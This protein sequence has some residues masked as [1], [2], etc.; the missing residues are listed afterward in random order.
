[1]EWVVFVTS[2]RLARK[3]ARVLAEEA[4]E[5]GAVVRA[6]GGS[7]ERDTVASRILQVLDRPRTA[8]QIADM[9][10]VSLRTVSGTLYRLNREGRVRALGRTSGRGCPLLWAL[11]E[12]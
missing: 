5:E 1:M 12:G 10:G 9:L 7:R 4:P 11:S 6:P 2:E 3:L 8:R